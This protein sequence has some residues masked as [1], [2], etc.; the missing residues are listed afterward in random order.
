MKIIISKIEDIKKY[1]PYVDL[2]EYRNSEYFESYFLEYFNSYSEQ[3][4]IL[5]E[6]LNHKGSRNIDRLFMQIVKQRNEEEINR[7]FDE[8]LCIYMAKERFNNEEEIRELKQRIRIVKNLILISEPS[9]MKRLQ[10][11][12]NKTGNLIDDVSMRNRRVDDKHIV[13]LLDSFDPVAALNVLTYSD[14]VISFR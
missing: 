10:D 1:N 5:K 3:I 2:L 9:N 13:L 8:Y 11:I 4:K 7:I 12:D 6:T 14:Y